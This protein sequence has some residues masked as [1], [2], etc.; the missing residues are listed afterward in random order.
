MCVAIDRV[1]GT[2]FEIREGKGIT[3]INN[4]NIHYND[5]QELSDE[6]KTLCDRNITLEECGKALAELPNGNLMVNLLARMDYRQIF[7]NSSGLM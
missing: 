4:F 5:I 3:C 6:S 2:N 7:T 1:I